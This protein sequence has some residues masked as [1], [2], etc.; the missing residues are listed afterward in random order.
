LALLGFSFNTSC[1]KDSARAKS[2]ASTA[3]VM[4]L[5]LGKASARLQAKAKAVMDNHRIDD[6]SEKRIGKLSS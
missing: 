2:P 4:S 6:T 5:G 1:N 3:A